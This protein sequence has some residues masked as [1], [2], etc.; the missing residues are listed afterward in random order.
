MI[1]PF[2]HSMATF[3]LRNASIALG[4]ALVNPIDSR[5]VKYFQ[6]AA[7][8]KQVNF[9][10]LSFLFLFFFVFCLSILSLAGNCDFLSDYAILMR[11]LLDYISRLDDL[12]I[13]C[14]LFLFL[15]LEPLLLHLSDG[16]L[17][18]SHFLPQ[19]KHLLIF[20]NLTLLKRGN[21]VGLSDNFLPHFKFG[22]HASFQ[23]YSS[24]TS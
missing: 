22:L 1:V 23:N 10:F 4:T 15:C 24:V 11:F 9:V 18:L 20:P 19:C 5:S 12:R 14:I 7:G 17:L 16:R 3:K 2:V 13:D 6:L 21:Q 8:L